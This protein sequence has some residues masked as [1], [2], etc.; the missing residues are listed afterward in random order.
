MRAWN[1]HLQRMY[2][3]FVCTYPSYSRTPSVTLPLPCSCHHS[4]R[5]TPAALLPSPYC[6]RLTPC[7][8]TPVAHRL[9]YLPTTYNIIYHRYTHTHTRILPAGPGRGQP[10]KEV[11]E[12]CKQ[13]RCSMPS[14]NTHIHTRTRPHRKQRKCPMT[15]PKSKNQDVSSPTFPPSPPTFSRTRN[16]RILERKSVRAKVRTSLGAQEQMNPIVK[17]RTNETL[18]RVEEQLK[19]K[20][21]RLL[22]KRKSKLLRAR[23]GECLGVQEQT[24]FGAQKSAKSEINLRAKVWS[25]PPVSGIRRHALAS[26]L[27]V[28]RRSLP[29]TEER[30]NSVDERNGSL[31][32]SPSP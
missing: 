5:Q 26:H 24:E 12:H 19:P 4:L 3:F 31:S 8:H 16:R 21:E 2:I 30:L 25:H 17:E 14:T 1:R 23:G 20:C 6:R 27:P 29:S 32:G 22:Q 18:E 7:H 13:R 15:P 10:R 28:W 9:T 11:P